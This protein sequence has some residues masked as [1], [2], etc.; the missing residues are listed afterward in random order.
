M[1]HTE[2]SETAGKAGTSATGT[3]AADADVAGAVALVGIGCRFPGGIDS[4]AS[5][6][7]F[8]TEGGV[9]TAPMPADRWA[10]Y[11]GISE[12][13]T[14][15]LRLAGRPGNFLGD[16]DGFDAEFF[17]IS[18]A[19]RSSWTPSSAWSS[20]WPGKHSNT[21]AISPASVAGSDAGVYIGTCSDD[22]GR[23]LLEDLPRI[24]AWT[25]IGAQLTG[26][27]NRLSHVLDL[28][29][30]SFVLDSACSAS[31]VA[32]HLACQALLAGET[33]L[34]LAGG[35]NIIGSPA[36]TLTLHAA[37]ALSAD[38]RSK[39]FDA[40]AD[41]YGRG[42]GCGVLVLKRLSDAARDG[43]RVLAVVRGSAVA[44]DGRT[45]GIMAPNP[46]AQRDLLRLAWQRAGLD[47]AT[48]ELCG[49][50]RDGHP[51]G[52]PGRGPRP[53]RGLRCG[54]GGGRPV[55]DRVG[56]VQ[57]R[58]RGASLR[59]CGHHQDGTDAGR[60]RAGGH[61]HLRRPEPR[62]RL[63]GMGGCGW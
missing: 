51:A 27:A 52:R 17:G 18:P 44:Q 33:S 24:E 13:F 37:G 25:G 1:K 61:C 40:E 50:A 58:A 2:A 42:E 11:Q 10:A 6:W 15:A 34:A 16:V 3:S 20:K 62:H 47:P 57:H 60:R 9:A 53:G 29:G 55:L 38:G 63:A 39:P 23:R 31:L 14:A 35:V 49:G 21:P 56:E 8:L 43:D 19:R 26:I 28:H 30:P 32:V 12:E 22:Y 5:F 59:R 54:P 4:P 45:S 7:E 36:Y 41:G 48:A 46:D